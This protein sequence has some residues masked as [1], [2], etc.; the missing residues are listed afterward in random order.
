[1]RKTLSKLASLSPLVILGFS[2]ANLYSATLTVSSAV[3]TL[4]QTAG[5]TDVDLDALTIV[6]TEG[7]FSLGSTL[8]EYVFWDNSQ[9]SNIVGVNASSGT[10]IGATTVA[11]GAFNGA[12]PDHWDTSIDGISSAPDYGVRAGDLSGEIDLSAYSSGTITFIYGTFVNDAEIT[13]NLSD[14]TS[15]LLGTDLSGGVFNTSSFTGTNTGTMYTSYDFD[16]SGGFDTFS[17]SATNADFDG[18][19]ARVLGIVMTDLV[20]VPEPSST[21]LLG[22]AA[23]F[24]L[25]RK[26]RR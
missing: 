16:T 8:G 4:G 9:S 6:G 21:G 11:S 10:S 5:S 3:T 22:I 13:A 25:F 19:R 23:S 14:G 24:L 15:D 2:T 26:K 1:M 12:A 7:T 20:A 17:Y 18:S